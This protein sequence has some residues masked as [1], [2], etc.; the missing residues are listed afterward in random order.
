M[1]R[2]DIS[3]SEKK[4]L[5]LETKKNKKIKKAGLGVVQKQ[6]AVIVDIYS[7]K[8]KTV[9]E[10]NAAIPE[11]EKPYPHGF[12]EKTPLLPPDLTPIVKQQQVILLKGKDGAVTAIRFWVPDVGF[13][14][15]D[16]W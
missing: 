1:P 16:L 15:V 12:K 13:M 6:P 4:R 10:N 9:Y 7:E 11:H 2:L 5:S 8:D 3:R 14:E